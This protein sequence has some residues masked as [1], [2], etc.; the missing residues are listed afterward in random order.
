MKG[1]GGGAMVITVA[2]AGWKSSGTGTITFAD[3]G[4]SVLL[5]YI[6]S[7][8]FALSNNGVAFG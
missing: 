4:D 7:K 2:N 8:W 5:Q 1:D 3:I 6:D